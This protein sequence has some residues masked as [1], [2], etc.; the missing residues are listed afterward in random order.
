MGANALARQGPR[1]PRLRNCRECG[2]EIDEHQK[3]AMLAAG[4]WQ[5]HNPDG[6]WRS[7]HINAL[8]APIGIGENW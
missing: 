2:A 4:K 7:Y 3:P 1:Q 6:L 5:A 8:Y